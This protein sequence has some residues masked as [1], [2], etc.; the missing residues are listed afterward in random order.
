MVHVGL[1]GGIASGKSTVAGMFR[2]KGAYLVDLDEV[3]H[4]LQKPRQP[5][6]EAMVAAFGRSILNVDGTINRPLLGDLVFRNGEKRALLNSIV[7]PAVFVEWR[8]IIAAVEKESPRAI[9]ISDVPLLIE[10]HLRDAVDVVLLVYISPEE[11]LERLIRRDGCGREDALIK[12]AAQMPIDE[13]VSYAHIVIDN[14]GT[15]DETR[16]RV[17]AAWEELLR[18]EEEKLLSD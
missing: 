11:Q 13:K 5:V 7:H 8:R 16:C 10:A 3:V 9:I 14:R 6:W 1:T 4:R 18:R 2:D 17:D 12:L 15:P